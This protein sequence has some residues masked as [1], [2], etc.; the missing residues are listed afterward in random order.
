MH[1]YKLRQAKTVTMSDLFK[2]KNL[3]QFNL[4]T[5]WTSLGAN[6]R[7]DKLIEEGL[8]Q[9]DRINVS[10]TKGA[11]EITGHVTPNQA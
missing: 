1:D 8:K 6:G 11:M 5:R 9:P 2:A 4:Y 3:P 7:P 10:F